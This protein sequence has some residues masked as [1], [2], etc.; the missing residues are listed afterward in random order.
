MHTQTKRSNKHTLVTHRPYPIGN[1][2]VDQNRKLSPD[3]KNQK[4]T[5]F[6]V[7]K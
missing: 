5:T 7:P 1:E 6:T 4:T 2:T 3:D